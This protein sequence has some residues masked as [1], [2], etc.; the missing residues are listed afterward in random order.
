MIYSEDLFAD[1]AVLKGVDEVGAVLT[2]PA[3]VYGIVRDLADRLHPQEVR[4]ALARGRVDVG[5]DERDVAMMDGPA[6]HRADELLDRVE[7][8]DLLFD[9]DLDRSP[10]QTAIAD[11]INLLLVLRGQ[12]T[13]RQREI[14]EQYERTSSQREVAAELGISQQAVSNAL[15][16]ANWQMTNTIENRLQRTL[17]AV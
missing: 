5:L 10:L 12:R 7:R 14:V 8:S 2:A 1:V 4:F 15:S 11:E 3:S 16:R 9:A 17:E 6:F 13:D